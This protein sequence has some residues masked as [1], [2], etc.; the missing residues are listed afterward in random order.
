MNSYMYQNFVD[1][2]V[3]KK[4]KSK[5]S[6][7]DKKTTL[8]YGVMLSFVAVAATLFLSTPVMTLASL[9]DD[10]VTILL[11]DD[12]EGFTTGDATQA[13]TVLENDG[14]EFEWTSDGGTGGCKD[15]TILVDIEDSRINITIVKDQGG[16]FKFC[17]E[18]DEQVDNPLI[19][20]FTSLNWFP[21]DDGII[22]GIDN[23]TNPT[24]LNETSVVFSPSAVDITINATE[25]GDAA[26]GAI[27]EF[28]YDLD[29]IHGDFFTGNKTWT[30][31]N[32]SFDANRCL[33]VLNATGDCV[34]EDLPG[35]DDGPLLGF[36]DTPNIFEDGFDT[37]FAPLLTDDGDGNYTLN[38]QVKSKGKNIDKISNSNPGAFYALTT[39]D[40]ATDLSFLEIWEDY[41]DCTEFGDDEI[42][43]LLSRK[44]T[45]NVKAYH[46]APD[47]NATDVSS[48]LYLSDGIEFITTVPGNPTGV[49]ATMA[50]VN[51]TDSSL[52]TAGSVVFLAVKFQDNLT[53]DVYMP[54]NPPD[55]RCVNEELVNATVNGEFFEDTFVAGLNMTNRTL[56]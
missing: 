35:D 10:E 24:P 20:N 32:Y 6:H 26:N 50:H 39:V 31:T 14:P 13:A 47:G 25:I 11:E 3:F 45:R 18:D 52:L 51:F 29:V 48:R 17:N 37:I 46:I 53:G 7:I 28:L 40:I 1:F 34:A 55:Y 38:L 33:G 27:F 54:E 36:G 8:T 22:I 4:I 9:I 56:I 15:A 23:F 19:F 21:D 2:L 30:F 41:G 16:N 42:A 44:L 5:T 49:N 43:K 12:G